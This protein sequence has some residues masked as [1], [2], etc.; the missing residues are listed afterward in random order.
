[1]LSRICFKSLFCGIC[2]VFRWKQRCDMVSHPACPA[3]QFNFTNQLTGPGQGEL[4]WL[5][6][7]LAI[8]VKCLKPNWFQG[9]LLISVGLPQCMWLEFGL[10]LHLLFHRVLKSLRPTYWSTET[11]PWSS[12]SSSCPSVCA[13]MTEKKPQLS[14]LLSGWERYQGFRS[15]SHEDCSVYQQL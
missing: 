4:N 13:A 14:S 9:H 12:R 5:L 7:A 10:L 3:D 1:M 15:F 11:A 6:G 2:T 8:N